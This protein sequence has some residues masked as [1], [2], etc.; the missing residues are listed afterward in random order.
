VKG[1]ESYEDLLHTLNN[2]KGVIKVYCEVSA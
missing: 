1:L 2:G